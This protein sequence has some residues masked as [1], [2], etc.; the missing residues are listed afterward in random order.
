MAYIQQR[1]ESLNENEINGFFN[2]HLKYRLQMLETVSLLGS[3]YPPETPLWTCMY[4]SMQIS[5]RMFIEFLGLG[6]SK[7]SPVLR[8]DRRYFSLDGTNS[9]EIKITDLGGR[10]VEINT[11]T[12]KDKELLAHAYMSGNRATAHLTFNAPF[13]PNPSKVLSASKLIRKLIKENLEME[14]GKI[15]SR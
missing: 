1:F 4:E 14:A 5:R 7:E 11:L 13:V 8:Q 6:I 3:K 12:E 9:Y 2:N 10:F 15:I